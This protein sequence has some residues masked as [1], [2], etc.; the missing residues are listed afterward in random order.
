MSVSDGRSDREPRVG[1]LEPNV[2]EPQGPP[3]RG[4]V[5][6]MGVAV[7]VLLMSIQLWLLA[8][9]F[10]F[11]LSGHDSDVLW[12]TAASGLIFLGGLLMLR[13]LHRAPRR[14]DRH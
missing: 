3:D 1:G 2:P 13:L 14:P 4:S 8:L 6:L 11:Y 9:A 5:V 10:E 12:I 7:G